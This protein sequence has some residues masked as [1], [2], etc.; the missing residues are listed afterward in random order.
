M[1]IASAGYAKG[2]EGAHLPA[3]LLAKED[4]SLSEMLRVVN[5]PGQPLSK[6]KLK[7]VIDKDG[8]AASPVLQVCMNMTSPPTATTRLDFRQ[9]APLFRKRLAFS[10]QAY[11]QMHRNA[12]YS[13]PMGRGAS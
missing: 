6:R 3:R 9:S 5:I 11:L 12:H 10:I 13:R 1:R 7:C 4:L 2:S 8:M